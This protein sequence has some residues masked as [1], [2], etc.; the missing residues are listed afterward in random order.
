M[1]NLSRIDLKRVF[2][3]F[4]AIAVILP[5]LTFAGNDKK[6]Y[7]DDNAGSKQNGSASHPYKTISKALDKANKNSEIH[8]AKGEYKETLEVPKGVEIYGAGSDK[9]IIKSKDDGKSTIYLKGS[10][11]LVD[12]NIKSGKQGINVAN[13]G[14]VKVINCKIEKNKANGI[15]ITAASLDES[16]QVMISETEISNNGQNGIYSQQR[17]VII[18]K[19]D[20]EENKSDGI[21]FE[22]GVRAW[23]GSTITKGN[24]GSGMVAT[25][26]R[27]QIFTKNNTYSNNKREGI[28]VN[29]YGVAGRIDINKSKIR[30]SGNYAVARIERKPMNVSIWNGLTVQNTSFVLSNKGDVSG[31]FRIYN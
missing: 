15:F 27:S 19:S 12:L 9:T 6:I 2:V 26:D 1:R 3:V 18:Y 10:A 17:N 22:A 30:N 20:I 25:L 29:A 13:G 7:V 23:I 28:E 14:R 16:S 11:T 24:H 5:F 21:Y 4:I 31:I 8:V